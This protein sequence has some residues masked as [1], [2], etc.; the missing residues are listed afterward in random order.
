MG[1]GGKISWDSVGQA[2][3]FCHQLPR[4]FV[5]LCHNAIADGNTEPCPHG[6]FAPWVG[7][8]SPALTLGCSLARTG[9]SLQRADLGSPVSLG[10]CWGPLRQRQQ[11]I[12]HWGKPRQPSAGSP[13]LPDAG[14]VLVLGVFF[15]W[16]QPCWGL[17]VWD[18]AAA[19]LQAACRADLPI[20]PVRGCAVGYM[21]LAWGVTGT[22]GDPRGPKSILGMA[23]GSSATPACSFAT[24][25]P[26]T[27]AVMSQSTFSVPG[28]GFHPPD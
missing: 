14:G 23:S 27:R 26:H 4:G 7:S 15:N 16:D 22:S 9:I 24:Q 3:G 20:C 18:G 1:W 28:F 8:P 17:L 6:M 11:L 13:A 21:L 19:G 5:C 12:N 2:E 10:P 25:S